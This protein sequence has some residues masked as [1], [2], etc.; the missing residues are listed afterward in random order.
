MSAVD[1]CPAVGSGRDLAVPVN[2]NRR[3]KQFRAT[4]MGLPNKAVWQFAI[5]S[6]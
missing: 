6:A 3:N 5:P 2:D 4:F 1:G